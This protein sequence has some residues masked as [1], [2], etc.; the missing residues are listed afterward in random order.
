MDL[1]KDGEKGSAAPVELFESEGRN[2]G[3]F[4]GLLRW[5]RCVERSGWRQIAAR[6]LSVWQT[7]SVRSAC[8]EMKTLSSTLLSLCVCGC[9]RLSL[10]I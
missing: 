10:H 1:T 8:R 5:T 9:R 7:P 4:F 3:V 6:S 2:L